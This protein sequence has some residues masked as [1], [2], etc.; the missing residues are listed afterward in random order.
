MRV[1]LLVTDLERGGTPLRLARLACGLRDAGVEIHVGC[2]APPGPVS[3]KL[4]TAGIPTF[5]CNARHSRDLLTLWRLAK[6]L[7]QIKPDLIHATLTHANVAARLV[8]FCQN[9]PVITST[10]TIEI[11]RRWHMFAEWLTGWLDHCHI[12]NS[13]AVAEHVARA[14]G[15]PRDNIYLVPPSLDMGRS[16]L[17]R[18]QARA[19]LDLA[20]HEFVILWA[21]RL[22][23]VKR[24][25]LIIKCAKLMN[26][27]PVR[28][29]ISGDGPDRARIERLLQSSSASRLVRCLG[30]RDDLDQLLAAADVFLFPSR[31]EGMPNAVLQAMSQGMPIVASDI[32]SLR[33]LSGD[34]Q[35]LL[36]AA[37]DDPRAFVNALTQ[38][39]E[40]PQLRKALGERAAAWAEQHLDPHETV[41]VLLWIYRDVL[42]RHPAK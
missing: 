24:V 6:H 3:D 17:D 12:V 28:F 13:Q 35:R 36:L 20:E 33:E 40:D 14:F 27:V 16:P 21:G 8:G 37:G 23:P 39:H 2:L 18:T 1:V 30:W 9:V 41:A 26:A 29:L 19:A 7:R 34:N 31:T 42:N 38:L 11:E 32:P 5:A 15:R 25:D 4:E 10:A 22:D